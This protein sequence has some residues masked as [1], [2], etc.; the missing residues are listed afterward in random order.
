MVRLSKFLET[1]KILPITPNFFIM[2]LLGLANILLALSKN[3]RTLGWNVP[4]INIGT[5]W[6]NPLYPGMD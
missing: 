3:L 5:L 4:S 6:K 1:F 2:D